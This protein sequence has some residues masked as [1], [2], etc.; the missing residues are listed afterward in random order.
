MP[1]RIKHHSCSL[2]LLWFLKHVPQLPGALHP[3]VHLSNLTINRISH[4]GQ[5]YSGVI[6]SHHLREDV[7]PKSLHVI[8]IS[9]TYSMRRYR[10]EDKVCFRVLHVLMAISLHFFII[11]SSVGLTKENPANADWSMESMRFLSPW[12]SRGFSFKNSLSKLL[13]SLGDF[14]VVQIREFS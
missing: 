13:Q 8:V 9:S 14:C 1:K 11:G 3:F 5:Q 12:E 6:L 7:K 10:E 2:W 4:S